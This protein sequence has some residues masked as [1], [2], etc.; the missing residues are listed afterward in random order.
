MKF[1]T[2]LLFCSIYIFSNAQNWFPVSKGPNSGQVTMISFEDKL[3]IG[4][5]FRTIDDLPA[6]G[7]AYW[8]EKKWNSFSVDG[9]PYSYFNAFGVYK[10]ELY[11]FAASFSSGNF[12]KM[13]KYDKLGNTWNS[14]PNSEV[15]DYFPPADGYNLGRV[16]HAI[17]FQDEFYIAGTFDRIGDLEVKNIAKWNGVEWKQVLDDFGNEV[18]FHNINALEVFNDQLIITGN[19]ESLNYQPYPGIVRWDGS[20]WS[21]FEG[22]IKADISNWGNTSAYEME[23]FQGEL[24]VEGRGLKIAGDNTIYPLAKWDGEDWYGI[25]NFEF[26]NIELKALKSF[27]DALFIGGDNEDGGFTYV[28]N[29]THTKKI[30]QTFTYPIF[31]FAVMKD[32]L[33]VSSAINP[34]T[35]SAESSVYRL[36]AITA[37]MSVE[38]TCNFF[39]NPTDGDFMISYETLENSTTTIRFYLPSGILIREEIF[40]DLKGNYL[41]KFNLDELHTGVY[42]VNIQS[43][44]FNESKVIMKN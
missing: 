42:I 7:I 25:K 5:F 40:N 3:F 18:V 23:V 39:P 41:R 1:I 10:E 31:N 16:Y 37:D 17:E 28:Y 19:I 24:Y 13:V 29:G 12:G 43:K 9:L 4:G 38:S 11:A 34:D 22:K 20:S 44:T 6:G 36:G 30:E 2:T 15:A 35:I 8:D 33:Y 26:G 32:Q 27:G 14:L 21:G